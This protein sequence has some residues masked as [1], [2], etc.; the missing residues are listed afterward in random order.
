M[1][2]W[3]ACSIICATII[4]FII[5]WHQSKEFR[6]I[7]VLSKVASCYALDMLLI[8]AFVNQFPIIV[9]S[10]SRKVYVGIVFSPR[11]ENGHCEFL[12]LLPLLSGYR[13]KENLKVTF[14]V[15]YQSLYMEQGI[16]SGVNCSKLCLED[17]ITLIPKQEIDNVSFFDFA[18]YEQFQLLKKK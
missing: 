1:L 7:G 14:S 2:I 10:K 15:N 6:R 16:S 18:T 5:K 4:A 3:S 17:F 9:T 12:T 11:L 8:D 13:D